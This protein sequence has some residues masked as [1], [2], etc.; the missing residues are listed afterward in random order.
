MGGITDSIKVGLPGGSSDP[1]FGGAQSHA[2]L[3]GSKIQAQLSNEAIDLQRLALDR[4]R[5]DLSPFVRLGE[6]GAPLLAGAIDDPSR[7]LDNPFFQAQAR[8]LEQQTLA[9]QAARGKVGSGG[10]QDILT[11]G[12]LG[13]GSQFQQQDVGNLSNLVRLGQASAAQVGAQTG[14]VAAAQGGIIGRQGQSLA[15]GQIG[16]G[17]AKAQG[18]ENAVGLGAAA[19]VGSRNRGAT[20]G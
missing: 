8:Q 6:V 14:N 4:I 1:F 7:V 12:I 2:S 15:A 5:G 9:Q 10:T 3:E 17:N 11:Q 13:L 19:F 16:A 20:N 18:L